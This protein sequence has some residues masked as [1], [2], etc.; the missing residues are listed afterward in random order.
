MLK[1][2]QDNKEPDFCII[3]PLKP[4]DKISKETKVSIKRNSKNFIWATYESDN[5]V[6]KNFKLGLEELS[7]KIKL[8]KYTIKIDNDTVWNRNTL[9]RMV[10]TLEKSELYFAYCYCSFEYKGSVNAKFP[11]VEFNGNRLIHSNYISSNSMFR[12]NILQEFPIID[13]DKYKRLLDWAYYLHLMRNKLIG[14][15]VENGYF[16]AQASE[17]SISAGS[18]E[19]YKIKYKRVFDDFIEPMLKEIEQWN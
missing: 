1:I 12:T 17:D 9:D 5:N 11:A 13:D 8:P 16:V 15:P 4:G 2:F 18:T 14:I 10:N 7:K 6:A 3:T 19:D